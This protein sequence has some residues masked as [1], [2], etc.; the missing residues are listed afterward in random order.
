MVFAPTLLKGWLVKQAGKE[1][2]IFSQASLETQELRLADSRFP[3]SYHFQ[4]V[5]SLVGPRDRMDILWTTEITT[6]LNDQLMI[7]Q[8]LARTIALTLSTVSTAVTVVRGYS[9]LVRPKLCLHT[10][11]QELIG[12]FIKHCVQRY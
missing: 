10:V 2:S 5:L 6:E 1:G 4:P 8:F 9:G 11:G 7:G 3:H 12:L